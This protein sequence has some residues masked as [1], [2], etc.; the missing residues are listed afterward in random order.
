MG[1]QRGIGFKHQLHPATAFTPSNSIYT[2]QQQQK[3]QHN[4]NTITELPGSGSSE[5]WDKGSIPVCPILFIEVPED[6]HKLISLSSHVFSITGNIS[7]GIDQTLSI[8]YKGI[9]NFLSNY[10]VNVSPFGTTEGIS[11]S[12]NY[13]KNDT[14]FPRIIQ[15]NHLHSEENYTLNANLNTN[16]I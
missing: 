9:L 16:P 11:V 1:L 12:F 3:L 14:D 4:N 15:L 2:Q 8:V 13:K 7:R 5:R 6:E 10:Q